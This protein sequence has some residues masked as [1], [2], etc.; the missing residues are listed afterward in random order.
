MRVS[1]GS[2]ILLGHGLGPIVPLEGRVTTNQY[3][4]ELSDHVCPL[5]K[6]F[7]VD[8]APIYGAMSLPILKV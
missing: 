4:V 7:C 1:G 8:N 6:H 2:A 3:K 5:F